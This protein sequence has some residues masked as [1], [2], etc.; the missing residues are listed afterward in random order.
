M[1]LFHSG[2]QQT[3]QEHDCLS[4]RSFLQRLGRTTASLP[5]L[6]FLTKCQEDNHQK[7]NIIMIMADDLGIEGLSCYGSTSYQTPRLDTLAQ[8]GIRFTHCHSTPLCTPSRVQLMTGQYNHRNYTEFGTLP[9]GSTTFAHL[10]KKAGYTTC[11]AGKWQLIGHYEGSNYRGK[12]STPVEAG[13]DEYCLWQVRTLGSRYWDPIIEQNGEFRQDLQ[14]R[15]APDIFCAYINDF[16]KRHRSRPF[17]I[18]YPMVL[19]HAPFIPTPLSQIPEERRHKTNKQFFPDMVAYMDRIVGRIVKNLDDLGLHQNTLILFTTDNG[20]DRR[21]QSRW[22]N[23]IIQGGKGYTTSAGTHV[24][25]IVNWPLTI[26][27][28]K[29]NNDLIDFTDFLPTLLEVAGYQVETGEAMD[30]R[31]FLPQILG[32]PGQSREWIFCHYDPKWGQWKKKQ[33]VYD[34]RWKLYNTGEFFDLGADPEEQN[35]ITFTI[36]NSEA[37]E[38]R[39]R[40]QVVLDSM[41]E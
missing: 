10:L 36:Q 35:P 41:K 12:G 23:R 11:V 25:L 1:T 38:A 5:L 20:T 29:V 33:F 15:Y 4:R 19:T 14:G 22:D 13:F 39:N 30:G 2:K 28:G 9:Q 8:T 16:V 27:S 18:Y 32:R 17:F 7:P 37:S 31:S 26:P 21:I 34:K 24:P 40:L 6:P 3:S